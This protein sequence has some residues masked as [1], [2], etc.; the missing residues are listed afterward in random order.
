MQARGQRKEEHKPDFVAETIACMKQ[1][2]QDPD[3]WES[4]G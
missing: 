4:A 3:S 1:S 2:Y